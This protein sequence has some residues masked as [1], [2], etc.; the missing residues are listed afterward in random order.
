MPR[1]EID[2]IVKNYTT[3]LPLLEKGLA[4]EDLDVVPYELL[5]TTGYVDNVNK[6]ASIPLR[7]CQYGL[8][9]KKYSKQL[10]YKDTVSDSTDG[11]HLSANTKDSFKRWGTPLKNAFK[12]ATCVLEATCMEKYYY[13]YNAL[14]E[15]TPTTPVTMSVP[16]IL[17]SYT[18]WGLNND[19]TQFF[20]S[21]DRWKDAKCTWSK[22]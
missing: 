11:L 15:L 14:I 20:C 3:E 19:H 7:S 9:W 8:Y 1:S 17:D 12:S 2:Q 10:Y 4:P 16:S 21:H 5:V 22:P 18:G 13:L 6:A